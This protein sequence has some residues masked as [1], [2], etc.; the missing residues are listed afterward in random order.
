M[1]GVAR[2]KFNQGNIAIMG[3]GLARATWKRGIPTGKM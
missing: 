3:I 2:A 1:P